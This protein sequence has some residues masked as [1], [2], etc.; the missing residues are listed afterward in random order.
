MA[1]KPKRIVVKF[2][3]GI[4]ANA[5]GTSLDTRQFRRLCAEIAGLVKA[6]HDVIVV[7]S[8]AV[9]AGASRWNWA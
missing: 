8:G 5:R 6:G 9:A 2:G 7:S 3:S 1:T 4:L